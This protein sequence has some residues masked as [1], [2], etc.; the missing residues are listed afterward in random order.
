MKQNIPIEE[1]LKKL[2]R[3]LVEKLLREA[4]KLPESAQARF[5]RNAA[6]RLTWI[7]TDH[8]RTIVYSALGWVVGEVLDHVLTIPI[9]FTKTV[10][11]LTAD[12]AHEI[13]PML[14]GVLGFFEDRTERLNRHRVARVIREEFQHAFNTASH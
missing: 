4:G 10:V 12:H 9:P 8:P 11:H 3:K 5:V 7:V 2:P 14:G 6:Q 13:A 1:L